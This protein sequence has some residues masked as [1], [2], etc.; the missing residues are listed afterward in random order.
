MKNNTQL[1]RR[2]FITGVSTLL[3]SHVLLPTN[4]LA[5]NSSTLLPSPI[6]GINLGVI[7]YSFRS[8]PHSALDILGYVV[9]LKMRAVEMMGESVELFAGAPRR[10]PQQSNMTEDEQ[11]E[12]LYR[13]QRELRQWR[14]DAPMDKY[15]ILKRM[16]KD[17]G[18]R[19]EVVQFRLDQMTEREIAYCFKVAKILGAKGITL[20]RSERAIAKVSPYANQHK[21][22]VGYHNHAEVNFNSWDQAMKQSK[23]NALNLDVGHYVAGTNESPLP[24]IRKYHDRILNLH[25]KDRKMDDGPNMPWGEGDTPLAEILR[26]MRDKQWPFMATIELEYDIPEGSNALK[27]VSNCIEFC[28]DALV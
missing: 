18:V 9:A 5:D 2:Q 11:R 13:Y 24:L 16:F 20:E 15:K 19:I 1:N 27:E 6:R 10:P 3:A 26:L 12:E 8:M 25:L 23:Y 14:L 7:S 28:K 21:R 22:T 17:E 4:I